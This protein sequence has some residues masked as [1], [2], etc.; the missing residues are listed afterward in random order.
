DA[1]DQRDTREILF[2]G[3]DRRGSSS[4][5]LSSVG[6]LES[7]VRSDRQVRER[8]IGVMEEHQISSSARIRTAEALVPGSDN[9]LKR[10]IVDA[11]EDVC[12]RQ[13]EQQQRDRG[14]VLSARRQTI[15]DAIDVVR[16]FDSAKAREMEQRY[17]RPPSL[18]RRIFGPH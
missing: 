10:R 9:A 12:E 6:A 15:D 1:A 13:W 2:R 7:Y 3:L 18:L 4:V 14:R 5:V 17:G 8:F 16:Q 11:M